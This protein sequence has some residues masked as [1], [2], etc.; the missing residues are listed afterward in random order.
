MYTTDDSL[1]LM[2]KIFGEETLK[3]K[4]FP[5]DWEA[6]LMYCLK[7]FL[8]VR[9][10]DIIENIFEKHRSLNEIA[11]GYSVT[12]ER[13]RQI[14]LRA[15][16]KLRGLPSI[17]IQRGCPVTVIDESFEDYL[18]DKMDVSSENRFKTASRYSDRYLGTHVIELGLNTKQINCL[19][20]LGIITIGDLIEC[21][22]E[23]LLNIRNMGVKSVEL[24]ED[25]LEKIGYSLKKD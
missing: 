15:I 5:T 17:L 18:E 19:R 13:I 20:Q 16:Q 8:S 22:R 6:M 14:E 2:T 21:S 10:N 7:R 4:E 11:E 3:E 25:Q 24:I 9:E 1:A 23:D 12:K